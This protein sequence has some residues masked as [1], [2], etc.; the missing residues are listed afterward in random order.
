MILSFTRLKEADVG[1]ESVI[2]LHYVKFQNIRNLTVRDCLL[3]VQIIFLYMITCPITK[4]DG[5]GCN[6]NTNSSHPHAHP[7]TPTQIFINDNQGEKET[8]VVHHIGLY[9]NCVE[10]IDMSGFQRV[11]GEE[12]EEHIHAHQFHCP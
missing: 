11:S 2:P 9:G 10:A 4:S 8:T 5:Y 7:P 6:S 1:E 3:H 12:G